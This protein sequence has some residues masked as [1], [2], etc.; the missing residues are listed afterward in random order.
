MPRHRIS[1][2]IVLALTA[3]AFADDKRLLGRDGHEDI[4]FA[5]ALLEQGGYPDLAEEV[6]KAVERSR[7]DSAAELEVFRAAMK[8]WNAEGEQDLKKR[9]ELMLEVLH[10]KEK[11]AEKYKG[12][13]VGE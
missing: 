6:A 4:E 5:R 8:Q 12:Q 2:G 1:V 3:S 10:E 11:F 13:P 9:E 7:K